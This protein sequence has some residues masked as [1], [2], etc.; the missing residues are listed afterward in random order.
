MSVIED[1]P[2]RRT[3]SKMPEPCFEW[4]P[5][6][7]DW[8]DITP[9]VTGWSWAAGQDHE[10]D[11]FRAGSGSLTLTEI[12][13]KASVPRLFDRQNTAS[14]FYPWL[15]VRKQIRYSVVWSGVRYPVWHAYI[16]EWGDTLEGDA[17]LDTSVSYVD[18]SAVFEGIDLPS[19][20][21]ELAVSFDNPTH[22]WRLDEANVT[23][24]VP[25]DT[26]TSRVSGFYD[27]GLPTLDATAIVPYDGERRCTTWDGAFINLPGY[28]PNAPQVGFSVEGWFRIAAADLPATSA[29]YP[30]WWFGRFDSNGTTYQYVQLDVPG[31]TAV[32]GGKLEA[33]FV[34]SGLINTV[35]T[36]DLVDDGLPHHF[37][38]EVALSGGT[39]SLYVDGSLVGS[40]H[41]VHTD[42]WGW[43]SA[44]TISQRGAIG[45]GYFTSSRNT[46]PGT[47]SHLVVFE[48]Q[49]LTATQISTHYDAGAT[50]FSGD[51]SGE[52]IDRILD[53]VGWPTLLRDID[54]GASTV[55]AFNLPG[56][57]LLDYIQQLVDTELGTLFFNGE[58]YIVFQSRHYRYLNARATTSQATFG[59]VH[60][61][62]TMFF[63]DEGFELAE[64][65]SLIRNPVI[66]AR[67]GGTSS[68]AEDV[69]LSDPE[70]GYG[71][72]SWS[73][74]SSRDRL[75]SAMRG[76]AR[77]LLN[78]F[79]EPKTRLKSARLSPSECTATWPVLLGAKFMDRWTVKRT[80]A[81]VGVQIVID[82]HLSALSH[83]G[84]P[85]TWETQ[86]VGSPVDDT[87][88]LII[89]TGKVG[90][91]KVG[92]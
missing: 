32:S 84:T 26:A 65:D 75:D 10:V 30:L 82:Q 3:S 67:E 6:G 83:S 89:G 80:P 88:Y 57:N 40:S 2:V 49:L 91:G 4:R 35:T 53:Y 42:D 87:D 52:A 69:R 68:T 12:P 15:K 63:D 86:V 48:G 28:V 29:V 55:G 66:A 81:N 59:D 14:P 17:R 8:C 90:T 46:F 38:V 62:A 85:T 20:W 73:A 64:D 33:M 23:G 22:W 78:W 36:T 56:G 61:D 5:T 41:S 24:A 9:Y 72:R 21:Y 51:K 60:S 1:A 34:S 11:R 43:V 50:G 70:T 71:P 92:Y 45:T 47:Q 25:I 31:S 18:A 19:S 37:V 13:S 74:P 44:G 76:R 54:T 79:K 7:V 77:W 58:N 16:S 39:I 27:Q